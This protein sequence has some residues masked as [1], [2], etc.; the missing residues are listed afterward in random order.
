MWLFTSSI[1]CYFNFVLQ[2]LHS[3][4]PHPVQFFLICSYSAFSGLSV[5][6]S[7]LFVII[8]LSLLIYLFSLPSSSMCISREK[9]IH[10]A[11]VVMSQCQEQCQEHRRC[12]I[13]ICPLMNRP[14][15]GFLLLGIH[16][17]VTLSK[18]WKLLNHFSAFYV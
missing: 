6:P 18:L 10:C 13:N 3:L 9:G 15:M 12:S 16:S 5:S 17:C 11:F 2:F 7:R 14:V 4:F 1:I 8:Y